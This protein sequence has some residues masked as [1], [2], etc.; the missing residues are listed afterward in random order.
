MIR[1]GIMEG[2][3]RESWL[4]YDSAREFYGVFNEI[5]V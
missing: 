4:L 3:L 5:S 1:I 2:K